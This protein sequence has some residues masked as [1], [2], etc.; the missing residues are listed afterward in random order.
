MDKLAYLPMHAT[1][2]DDAGR[3]AAPT[4]RDHLK[5][6]PDPDGDVREGLI[7]RIQA[8]RIRHLVSELPK[9]ERTIITLR[10]GLD[11]QS[12]SRREIAHRLNLRPAAVR[13]IETEALQLL[14]SVIL[15][16]R[17]VA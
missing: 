15:A 11:G 13:R 2:L 7:S 16:P 8:T 6:V 12:L 14:R 10:F 9:L 5:L 17:E 1:K 3:A 4:V